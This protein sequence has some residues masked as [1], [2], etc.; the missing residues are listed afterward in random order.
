MNGLRKIGGTRERRP[1][2]R[3]YGESHTH[4][5]QG[6]RRDQF[7]PQDVQHTRLLHEVGYATATRLSLGV[8]SEGRTVAPFLLVK[9]RNNGNQAVGSGPTSAI[10]RFMISIFAMRPEITFNSYS[11]PCRFNS[12]TTL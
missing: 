5:N 8:P 7:L 11:K 1:R 2:I 10:S 6:R 12:Q 4:R 3:R 9:S